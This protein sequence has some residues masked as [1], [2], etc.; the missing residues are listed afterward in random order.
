MSYLKMPY[1]KMPCLKM[2]CF[3][4]CLNILCS[5]VHNVSEEVI[6]KK[7]KIGKYIRTLF[8]AYQKFSNIF[9]GPST[10]A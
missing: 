8:V 6:K 2:P 9:D 5:D 1:L 10:F 3:W 7:K 4:K